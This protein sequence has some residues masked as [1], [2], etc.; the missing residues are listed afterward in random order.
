MQSEPARYGDWEVLSE[1]PTPRGERKKILCRCK[2]GEIRAVIFDNLKRGG[3]TQCHR[4]AKTRH[5]KR[6]S[7]AYSVWAD[8][9]Y[10][11]TNKNSRMYKHYGERGITVCE[12]WRDFANFYEDMGDPS[13]G[14]SIERV[15][16]NA[17]YS[18]DNCIWA[19]R[20][21]QKN[22]RRITVKIPVLGQ[23]VPLSVISEATGI[24]NKILYSRVKRRGTIFHGRGITLSEIDVYKKLKELT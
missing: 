18:P 24:P 23:Y 3:S 19:D 7:K 22:N 10:R 20:K 9:L 11:C 5:K 2:C 1:L 6:K 12:R 4:C 21:T 17:G 13:P 8:M 14:L 15:D 16:N